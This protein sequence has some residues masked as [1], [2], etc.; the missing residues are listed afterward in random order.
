MS[1]AQGLVA[2][3]FRQPRQA[4]ERALGGAGDGALIEALGQ[5]VDRLDRR[6]AVELLRVHH[7]VGMD[8]LPPAVPELELAGNPARGA[9]RQPRAHPFVIG[10]EEDQLDVAGVVLD[11]HLERRP[12]ARVRRLAMLGHLGLDGDDRVGNRVADLGPRAPVDGRLRQ[13]EEDVDHP[14]ALRLIEQAIEQFR[15]L[16]P[17]PRQG[18]GGREQ[19]IESEGRITR[20]LAAPDR[21]RQ[22]G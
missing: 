13:M 18:A 5:P 9:D 15:V 3:P 16:R 17:D 4:L 21:P 19:R 10:E 6:Q 12:R 2:D 11:Q 1:S 20:P 8:D 7:P 22:D 14:R